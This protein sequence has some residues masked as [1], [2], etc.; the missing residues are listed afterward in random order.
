MRVKF[1]KTVEG[2]R[3]RSGSHGTSTGDPYG[4]FLL[5]RGIEKFKVRIY[6][7]LDTGW[8]HVSVSTKKRCPTRDDMCWIKSL[9]FRSDETVM[10]IHPHADD[11]VNDHPYCLHLWRPINGFDTPPPILV[12]VGRKR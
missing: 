10:Q 9:F 1:N 6:D 12:G 2:G 5:T 11:Y 7:G 3:F 4:A 8:D